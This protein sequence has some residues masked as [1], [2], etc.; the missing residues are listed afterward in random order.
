MIQTMQAF[1][2]QTFKRFDDRNSSAVFENFEFRN[3]SFNNC[4]I[5]NT[6]APELRSTIRHVELFDCAANACYV[7]EAIVEDVLVEDFSTHKIFQIFGAVFKHVTLRGKF[8]R[9]MINNACL[10]DF[11]VNPPYQY[12]K[13]EALKKA[14]AEYYRNVDWALDISQGEFKYLELR[15][16]P[17]QL[18]NRD[19]ETQVVVSKQRLLDGED[20]KYLEFKVAPWQMSFQRL[21]NEEPEDIVLIV[22]KRHRRFREYMEDLQLLRDAGIADP[23]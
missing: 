10:P 4:S 7:D 3:C 9:L 19:Q 23:D 5:S 8:N 22:P 16:I 20:W 2:N 13:G 15:G 17:S 14:N 6:N 1:E 12:E 21:L 18:I 11:S